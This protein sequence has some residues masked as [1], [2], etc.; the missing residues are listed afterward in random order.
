MAK[1]FMMPIVQAAHI[2]VATGGAEKFHLL[3]EFYHLGQT[4]LAFG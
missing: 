2:I 4:E 1:I 3:R